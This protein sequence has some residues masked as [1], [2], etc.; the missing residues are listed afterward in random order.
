MKN[1]KET[2]AT[3]PTIVVDLTKVETTNDIADA[4]ITA[5]VNA[6]VALTKADLATAKAIIADRIFSELNEIINCFEETVPVIEDDK[7]ARDIIKLVE[8][9]VAKK[10]PWYKRAWNWVK[11]PFTKKK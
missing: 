6:G 9:R 4:F 1:T 2:K 5:K 8:K 10:Q 11:K 3:K 7:L